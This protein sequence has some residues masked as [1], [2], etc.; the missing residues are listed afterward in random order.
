MLYFKKCSQNAVKPG[1]RAKIDAYFSA[2]TIINIQ[3]STGEIHLSNNKKQGNVKA[4][5]TQCFRGF[6]GVPDTIRTC[7]LQ[8]RSLSLYPAELQ[9][10]MHQIFIFQGL[11]K[12]SVGDR[13]P[14]VF[15]NPRRSLCFSKKVSNLGK[16]C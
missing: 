3:S 4:P 6:H 11:P 5:K 16:N 1:F 14:R 2:Y 7:D 15:G 8:S 12:Y 10:H 13:E 9:A